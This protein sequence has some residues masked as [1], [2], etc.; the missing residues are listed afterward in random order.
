MPLS[1]SAKERFAPPTCDGHRGP[2]Q[3]STSRR[4][5]CPGNSSD[6]LPRIARIFS[7]CK[8]CVRRNNLLTLGGWSADGRGTRF[9]I[10][11]TFTLRSFVVGKQRGYVCQTEKNKD[12]LLYDGI[13]LH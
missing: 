10:F 7:H 13:A 5:T 3:E 6:M 2:F 9:P 11:I 8:G 12:R 4:S 1:G